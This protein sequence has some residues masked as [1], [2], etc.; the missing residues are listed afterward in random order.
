MTPEAVPPTRPTQVELKGKHLETVRRYTDEFTWDEIFPFVTGPRRQELMKLISSLYP[1]LLTEEDARALLSCETYRFAAVANGHGARKPDAAE[2]PKLNADFTDSLKKRIES[3]PDTYRVRI[4]LPSF[5]KQV[6]SALT[7]TA[8]VRIVIAAAPV[9]KTASEKS[10]LS[11]LARALSDM[12]QPLQSF[13]EIDVSGFCDGSA[14]SSAAGRCISTAK[15][16][17]FLL[18]AHGAAHDEWSEKVASATFAPSPYTSSDADFEMPAGLGRC[19]GRLVASESNWIVFGGGRGLATSLLGSG[20]KP[21]TESERIDAFK[22][23]LFP[24]G[25]FLDCRGHRDFTSIAA[26]MEWHQD[27][28]WA[29]NQTFAYLAAC[30]GLEAVLGSDGHMEGMS[31]RLADRYAFL[32]G[33]GRAEREELVKQYDEV[34]NLRGRL[35]HAKA[36]RLKSKDEGLLRRAQAMLMRVIWHEMHEMYRTI[37]KEK[38]APGALG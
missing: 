2:W 11:S 25:R 37:E 28:L 15:Q 27:S 24:V 36:A 31:R 34:L 29:D 18:T 16:C 26:A 7:I 5:P 6:E 13:L 9:G 33:R 21:E 8:D 10:G 30:I 20:R 14:S 35:V 22:T 4:S 1:D 32:V 17:S 19:F 23:S 3:L 12:H 38:E